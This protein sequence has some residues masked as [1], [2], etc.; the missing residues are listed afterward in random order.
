MPALSWP[1]TP[2]SSLDESLYRL[3]VCLPGNAKRLLFRK[4]TKDLDEKW[5]HGKGQITI[6]GS[7]N[8]IGCTQ[9]QEEEEGGN[10]PEFEVRRHRDDMVRAGE[11]NEAES[12]DYDRDFSRCYPRLAMVAS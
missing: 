8:A 10:K 11:V 12:E 3:P 9:T 7:G 6:S 1:R 5:P 4:I 2:A